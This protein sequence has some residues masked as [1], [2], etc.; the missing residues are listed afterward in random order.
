MAAL[1]ASRKA[2]EHLGFAPLAEAAQSG[3]IE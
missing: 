1:F 2:L 3:E